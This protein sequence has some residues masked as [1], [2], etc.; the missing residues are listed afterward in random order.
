MASHALQLGSAPGLLSN[1]HFANTSF[2]KRSIPASEPPIASGCTSA[3]LHFLIRP[4]KRLRQGRTFNPLI[5]PPHLKVDVFSRTLST[6]R[7]HRSGLCR[8]EIVETDA[9]T[10][11]KEAS[12]A[13]E[14]PKAQAVSSASNGTS[15][16]ADNGADETIEHPDGKGEPPF[17]ALENARVEWEDAIKE[18]EEAREQR[19]KLEEAAQ[20]VAER[21]VLLNEE[22]A[23]KQDE[24]DATAAKVKED[25]LAQL[26]SV[27]CGRLR[28]LSS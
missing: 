13:P 27:K 18:E 28:E 17:S 1:C 8:A 2:P 22:A 7:S 12:S 20:A 16:S 9:P 5:A 10:Q 15:G 25:M 6:R 21:A 3:R 4:S 19:S 24:C 11:E 26:F 14:Q 23:S